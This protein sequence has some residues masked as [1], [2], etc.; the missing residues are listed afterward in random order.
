[1]TK[2][3]IALTL[4]FVLTLV[5]FGLFAMFSNPNFYRLGFMSYAAIVGAV[6]AFVWVFLGDLQ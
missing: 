5:G 1:M 3:L 2:V 4:F 6:L